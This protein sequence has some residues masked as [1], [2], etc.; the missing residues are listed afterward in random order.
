[1]ILPNPDHLCSSSATSARQALTALS[2][3]AMPDTESK[4]AQI[5]KLHVYTP[6]TAVAR[7]EAEAAWIRETSPRKAECIL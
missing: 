2:P 6:E 3:L 4:A 7:A 5:P 1:L